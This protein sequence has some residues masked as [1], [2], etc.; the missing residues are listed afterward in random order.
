MFEC[1]VLIGLN[2]QVTLQAVAVFEKDFDS[3]EG[4]VAPCNE[5]K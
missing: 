1:Y 5:Q 2:E 4:L 3:I